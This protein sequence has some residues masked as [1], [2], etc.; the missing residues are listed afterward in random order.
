MR[1]TSPQ[2]T[3]AFGAQL[4]ASLP[5]R[6]D[7]P[8]IVY[9]SGDLGAG[10]TTF[11]K[12]FIHGRG[13]TE[14]VRSPTYALVEAY[15]QAGLT[16]LHL[17]LYRLRDPSELALLGLRDWARAGNVWLVEWPEKG[18]A[19]LPAPDVRIV[20]SVAADAHLIE[21]VAA[22]AFGRTWL[23]GVNTT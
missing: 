5:E 21:P 11:A 12:G 14:E 13:V 2:H 6:K 23:E 16:L 15:E 7:G 4:A 3:E 17:D 22:S 18:G 20:L 8:V 1:S 9:L 19:D 10:K